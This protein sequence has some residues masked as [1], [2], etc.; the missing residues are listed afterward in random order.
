[1]SIAADLE[2]TSIRIR[3]LLQRGNDEIVA[4]GPELLH[5][6]DLIVERVR[7]LEFVAVI[8]ADLLK[9]FQKKGGIDV[10]AGN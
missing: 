1:M 6:V 2:K 5:E 3:C 4:K 8:N 10:T 9:E 7:G